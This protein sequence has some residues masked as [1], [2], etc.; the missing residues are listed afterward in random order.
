MEA[1]G[2]LGALLT[3]IGGILIGIVGVIELAQQ[4]PVAWFAG[5]SLLVLGVG[6]LLWA[7]PSLLGRAPS[8]PPV[9]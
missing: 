8:R 2:R 6:L 5:L 4:D 7:L 9:G 3:V 1:V